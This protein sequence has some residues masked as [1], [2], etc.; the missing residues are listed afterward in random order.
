MLSRHPPHLQE[1]LPASALCNADDN[2]VWF[3][4]HIGCCG[5]A[6]I[7][8]KRLLCGVVSILCIALVVWLVCAEVACGILC[9]AV[10]LLSFYVQ[11]FALWH[12]RRPVCSCGCFHFV[13]S[14]CCVDVHL[15]Y[16]ERLLW[17]LPTFCLQGL[18][19]RFA[20]VLCTAIAVWHCPYPVH[21]VAV[22]C[23]FYL[24]F[25]GCSVAWPL[26]CLQ[27]L[28]CGFESILC[29]AVGVWQCA[30]PELVVLESALPRIRL[31]P[32]KIW[33]GRSRLNPQISFG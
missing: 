6:S 28:Q 8:F 22:W 29:T 13:H 2:T 19:C 7:L 23:C 26:P 4:V 25:G 3:R 20:S 17:H 33:Y 24:T 11:R 5:S 21:R 10:V 32:P 16:A 1:T 14:G 30:Y 9:P 31:P 18:L 15:S 12:W 27:R